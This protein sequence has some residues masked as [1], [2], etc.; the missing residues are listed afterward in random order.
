MPEPSQT[1]TSTHNHKVIEDAII[2]ACEGLYRADKAIDAAI[3]KHIADLRQD[4][5]DIKKK[6]RETYQIPAKLLQARYATYR[7]EQQAIDA[8]DDATLDTIRLL[9]R[10]LPVG[11]SVDM[12]RAAQDSV[13]PEQANKQG[14]DAGLAGKDRDSNPYDDGTEQHDHWARGWDAGQRQA[15]ANMG[16]SPTEEAKNAAQAE[17]EP[18]PAGAA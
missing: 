15:V 5:A 1:V 9:H 6:M 13:T 18:E 14:V 16:K 10:A 4:K 11:G 17:S 2:K 12:V 7:L 8:G 3:E